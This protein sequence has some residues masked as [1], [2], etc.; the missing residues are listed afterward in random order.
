MF[1][2]SGKTGFLSASAL[3]GEGWVA[4]REGGSSLG[5]P[6]LRA[7][8]SRGAGLG[9]QRRLSPGCDSPQ[10]PGLGGQPK[11]RMHH[12]LHVTLCIA[13]SS[14]PH[15]C[16]FILPPSLSLTHRRSLLLLFSQTV[17]STCLPPPL[18]HVPASVL[19]FLSVCPVEV[20]SPEASTRG[21]RPHKP[22][23]SN[24]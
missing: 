2:A 16:A 8:N 3:P 10:S 21:R 17:L 20:R 12:L 22:P 19:V 18:L 1:Q 5:S 11:C 15:R 4:G 6:T 13:L 7:G 24:T 14:P 23:G 9:S